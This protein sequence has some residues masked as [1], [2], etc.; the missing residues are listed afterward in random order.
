MEAGYLS[1]PMEE[2]LGAE[3]KFVVSPLETTQDVSSERINTSQSYIELIDS[4]APQIK[5]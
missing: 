4:K 1:S 3:K 2:G 5:L